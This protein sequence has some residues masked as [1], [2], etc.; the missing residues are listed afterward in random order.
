MSVAVIARVIL[1]GILVKIIAW[2]DRVVGRSWIVPVDQSQ[3]VVA[4]EFVIRQV[5][6]DSVVNL[7]LVRWHIA[8]IAPK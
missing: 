1:H 2:D 8:I 3:Q 4:R 7:L 5:S 6:R